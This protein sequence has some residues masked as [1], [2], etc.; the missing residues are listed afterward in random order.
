MFPAPTEYRKEHEM[1]SAWVRS[2]SKLSGTVVVRMLAA[3]CAALMVLCLYSTTAFGQCMETWTDD[4][5]NW[6]DSRNWT[7]H[8]VPNSSTNTCITDGTSTVTLNYGGQTA[9][10]QLAGGNTLNFSSAELTVF[11]TQII[12][13]GQINVNGGELYLAEY[14]NDVTLTGGGTVTLSGGD[15]SNHANTLNNVD[16]TIQGE[17]LIYNGGTTLINGGTID[18]NST[19]GPLGTTLTLEYGTV[20]NTGLLEATN[21]GVLQLYGNGRINNAGGSITASGSGATVIVDGSTIQGGT[22]NNNTGGTMESIGATLD[23]NT[24]GALTLSSGSTYTTTPGS[25]TYVLGTINNQGNFQV[26]GGSSYQNTF[27]QAIAN[28]TL[29]GSGGGT[30]TLNT[31]V[32]GRLN[33][34]LTNAYTLDNVN[35]T[36]QGEGIIGNNIGATLINEAGGT[37]IANST[38]GSLID[39]L[40]LL[41]GNITNRGLLEATNSGVLVLGLPDFAIT[42][43]NA[44]GNI[45][46]NG[47][48][49]TV[50]LEGATIQGGTLNTLAGGTLETY[51]GAKLDGSTHG[52]LTLSSGSTYTTPAGYETDVLGTINNQGNFLVNGGGSLQTTANTTLQGGGTVSLS[53]TIGGYGPAYL[54]Q[55]GPYTLDNVNNTIQGEGVIENN[56]ATIINE[57]GGTII[58]NSTGSPLTTTLEIDGGTVTNNGTF[59]ANSGDTLHLVGGSFTNFSGNTLT[60]GIYNIYGTLRI[61][62]LGTG[63]GEI[64]NNASTILL[65]GPNSSFVDATVGLA[66]NAL[67]NFNNNTATGSFTIQ[68]GANFTGSGDFANAG[69]VNVGS[70]STFTTGGVGNYNQSGGITQLNGTLNT[71]GGQANFNGGVLFGNGG[72][73]TGN[74]MMAGT[75]A[76]AGTISDHNVPLTPGTLNINGNY[77]QTGAGIF[78]LGIGGTSAGTFGL[79]TVGGIASLNGTLNINLLNGFFPTDGETFTFLTAAGGVNSMFS[80]VNGLYIGHDEDLIVVYNPNNVEIKA[81]LFVPVNDNWNG[82]TDVW[83][84]ASK[85]SLGTVPMGENDVLIYSGG[86][87]LV[88][89]DVGSTTVN[90]LTLGGVL[91]NHTYSELRDG[92]VAQTLNI[93]SGLTVGQSGYLQL[94]GGSNVT[95]LADSSNAG[96][97]DLYN[98]STLSIGGNFQ[99]QNSGGYPPYIYLFTGSVLTV[100]G[101]FD[102]QG[103]VETGEIGGGSQINVAG[104]F[105][106]E[107]GAAVEILG[108]GDSANIGKLVNSG[109][110][111]INS[112]ATAATRIGSVVN[113]GTGF[114]DL[115]NGSKLTVRG[116]VDNQGSI[117]TSF[118]AGSG[119]NTITI[120]GTLTNSP[121]AQF[122]LLN[123]T[124]MLI[125][126]GNGGV[127]LF[128]GAALSTPTLNNGG[129]INVDSRSTLL[130]GV[131]PSHGFGFGYNYTQTAS[132]TLGEMITPTGYGVIHLNGGSALLDGTLDILLQSGFDPKVGSTYEFLMGAAPDELNGTFD[133]ILNDTFNDGTE[134]WLVTYDNADGY[135]ELIAA[136]ATTTPEPSS[137]LLF[138]SGL[139]CLGYSIRR[140]IAK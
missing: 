130:I 33:A 113:N 63:G 3:T 11:G 120:N 88:T 131:P 97:I 41:G 18:A 84:N 61:D 138:G 29:S 20:N 53:S 92:G 60:G 125:I 30:V 124:D 99:N 115:E 76:P 59:Q 116:N 87:D 139:L 56:G 135:V 32:G 117:Y 62:S 52:A 10:L 35:N 15:I 132:G 5:G 98:G 55:N 28:T 65:D 34:G 39:T 103:S 128:N 45:T 78:N 36:I 42:I 136:T 24:H 106:N 100:A 93:S 118:Y 108:S 43:N 2:T 121:G 4:N 104:T 129:T 71:G 37:I 137:F 96:Q 14:P 94:T 46:A 81:H 19:G 112:G 126:N 110:F 68:D 31:P 70:N 133:Y 9:D 111:F 90:S 21:S 22:L 82:G 69:T 85:W 127:N 123:P 107:A 44:G 1:K 7:P 102:N 51:G 16:N 109:F 77:T 75:I 83:S 13:A 17:G 73:I 25:S 49:A 119:D 54:Y 26:N 38:G 58:A 122:A 40:E 48:S 89:L 12:N 91:N 134:K 23:G 101:N 27:L 105:T 140:R 47:P 57:A 67:S 79:L 72:T 66:G 64:V 8:Q 80:T 86:A 95:T 6:G 50:Q 74:V 114:I